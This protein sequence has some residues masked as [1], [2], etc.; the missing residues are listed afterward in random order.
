MTTWCTTSCYGKRQIAMALLLFC[1]SKDQKKE[2]CNI[3]IREQSQFETHI[4]RSVARLWHHC[5]WFP[6]ATDRTSWSPMTLIKSGSEPLILL[7]GFFLLYFYMLYFQGGGYSSVRAIVYARMPRYVR[8]CVFVR[9]RACVRA[10][11]WVRACVRACVCV[12]VCVRACV[13]VCV[14]WPV[15]ALSSHETIRHK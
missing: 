3:T 9:V 4:T 15:S 2:S 14:C 8:L 5:L 12:C 10:D 11:G 7:F 6:M 1:R 13:R